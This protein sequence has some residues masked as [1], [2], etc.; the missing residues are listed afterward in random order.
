MVQLENK[1]RAKDDERGWLS[2]KVKLPIEYDLVEVKDQYGGK[3]LG[4]FG[5]NEWHFGR[6]RIRG[7]VHYWRTLRK[8][9]H[10]LRVVYD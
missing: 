1:S 9:P 7:E 8:S 3:Q 2:V 4:W 5:F 6:K 10:E